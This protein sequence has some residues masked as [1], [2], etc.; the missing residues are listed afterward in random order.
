MCTER[1]DYEEGLSQED[2]RK[3]RPKFLEIGSDSK[4]EFRRVSR[5]AEAQTTKSNGPV[6]GAG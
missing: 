5:E 4:F 1:G 6:S 3:K 2:V